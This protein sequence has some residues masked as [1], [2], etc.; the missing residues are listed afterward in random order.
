MNDMVGII[1]QEIDITELKNEIINALERSSRRTPEHVS[2]ISSDK[3]QLFDADTLKGKLTISFYP[4]QRK[5]LT[6]ANPETLKHFVRIYGNA[7]NKLTNNSLIT[8]NQI[9]SASQN[10]DMDENELTQSQEQ[11]ENDVCIEEWHNVEICPTQSPTSVDNQ[12]DIRPS[13]AEEVEIGRLSKIDPTISEHTAPVSE[14][15]FIRFQQSIVADFHA[16][17]EMQK[18]LLNKVPDVSEVFKRIK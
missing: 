5:V 3:I 4:A 16:M 11:T 14:A 15:V 1:R 2:H 7:I 9:A 10:W 8:S 17:K 12:V 13:L 6:Q 18:E